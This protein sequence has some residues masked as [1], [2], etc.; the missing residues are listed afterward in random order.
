MNGIPALIKQLT[1]LPYPSPVGGHPGEALAVNQKERPH[2][3]I[4]GP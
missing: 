1:E 4:L 3:A 2:S